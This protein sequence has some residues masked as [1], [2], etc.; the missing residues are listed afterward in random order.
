V[1]VKLAFFKKAGVIF[2]TLKLQNSQKR[3]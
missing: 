2:C 1:S 3:E